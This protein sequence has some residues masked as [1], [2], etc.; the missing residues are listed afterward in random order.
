[1]IEALAVLQAPWPQ[2]GGDRAWKHIWFALDDG[3]RFTLDKFKVSTLNLSTITPN[4][5]GYLRL[6]HHFNSNQKKPTLARPIHNP[7]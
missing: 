4:R 2:D 6:H 3:K 1:M 5:L 7:L